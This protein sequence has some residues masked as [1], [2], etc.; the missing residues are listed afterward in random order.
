MT[1]TE[2]GH[3]HVTYCEGWDPGSKTVI[4]AI[5]VAA[6]RARHAAGEP[7]AV[8][9]SAPPGKPLALLH[10]DGRSGYLG[11][12]HFDDSARR[13]CEYDYRQLD[14]TTM[15]LRHYK[16][17]GYTTADQPEFDAPIAFAVTIGRDGKA[18]RILNHQGTFD[19]RALVPAEYHR[20]PPVHFGR[21]PFDADCLTPP[22]PFEF[23]DT[24]DPAGPL[25][26]R[27][28]QPPWQAPAGLRPRHL[29]AMFT[30]GALLRDT[31]G[32]IAEIREPVHAGLVHFP[33]GQVVAADPGVLDP[34]HTPFTVTVPAGSYPM[35][36][37]RMQWQGRGWGENPAAKL[38][39]SS[40]QTISWEL[41]VTPG[42]DTRLLGHGEFY[43]FGVD[44]GT[45]AFLDASGCAPLADAVE[46]HWQDSPSNETTEYPEISDA[47]T[48]TNLFIYSAGRGDGCYPVWIGRDTEGEVTC[49]IADMLILDDA[50]PHP[51]TAEIRSPLAPS[52]HALAPDDTDSHEPVAQPGATGAYFINLFNKTIQDRQQALTSADAFRAHA[53]SAII[54]PR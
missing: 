33:T 20:M 37:A 18:R 34:D 42:Q 11:I 46:R 30:A 6:A 12:F 44:S 23:V 24:P 54:P 9:L 13:V 16:L 19:T 27:A 53:R 50:A 48:G 51:P 32:E 1:T 31:D 22:T 21:W 26:A 36:V 45:G 47:A 17:W 4:G 39:I 14:D 8:L 29:E 3:I 25:Q 10:I 2:S 28:S 15:H 41:A 35:L 40:K 43:G 5:P 52:R 38:Q 49:F 7:Y